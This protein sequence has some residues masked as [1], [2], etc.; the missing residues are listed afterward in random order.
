MKILYIIKSC[1]S[2]YSTR[3]SFIKDGWIRKI[4]SDSDYVVIT[5]SIGDEKT[6]R[7]NCGD[8]YIS[9]AEKVRS[10]LNN[11]Q[12]EGY[13][14]YFLIDDDVFVFPEKLENYINEKNIESD[15]PTIIAN[16]NCYFSEMKEDSFC[17]GAGVLMTKKTIS[18]FKNFISEDSE[19]CGYGCDDCCL[20][21]LSLK[22][23]LEIINNSPGDSSF[24]GFIPTDYKENHA[25]RERIDECILLHMIRS[26]SEHKEL[27]KKFYE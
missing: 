6:Y 26:E 5:S 24:G 9:T 15:S 13:D 10:F 11:Y 7:C 12:F 4:N 27:Y 25:I 14:W 21:C 22:L 3:V 17:G 16:V 23:K 1:D 18:L 2:Y 8:T 20:F 19:S